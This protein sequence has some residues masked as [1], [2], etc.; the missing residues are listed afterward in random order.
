MCYEMII[1]FQNQKWNK[2]FKYFIPM[3]LWINLDTV[4]LVQYI[5]K[6]LLHILYVYYIKYVYIKY[7]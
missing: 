7:L 6:C 2:Y 4:Y 5:S 1:K 3:C